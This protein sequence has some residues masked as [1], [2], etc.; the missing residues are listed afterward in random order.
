M[1][2]LS[3]GHPVS[4]DG[5]SFQPGPVWLQSLT[6]NH[7]LTHCSDTSGVGPPRHVSLKAQEVI[8]TPVSGSGA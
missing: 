5:P 4:N 1:W 8:L 7:V 6:L 2:K 3:Q